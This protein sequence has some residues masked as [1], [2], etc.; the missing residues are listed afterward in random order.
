M[1]RCL[2]S[3]LA[4]RMNVRTLF[5][6]LL[7]LV[8]YSEAG[9]SVE[10]VPIDVPELSIENKCEAYNFKI[11][12]VSSR[13]YHYVETYRGQEKASRDLYPELP[14]WQEYTQENIDIYRIRLAEW[15]IIRDKLCGK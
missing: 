11:D 14:K 2:D 12:E 4:W 3:I 9:K 10:L 8:I 1:K 6:S 5:Y 13:L 15:L 7:I